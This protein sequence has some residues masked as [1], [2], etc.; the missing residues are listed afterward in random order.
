MTNPSFS[1]FISLFSS[2]PEGLVWNQASGFAPFAKSITTYE[3]IVV[4]GQVLSPFT[5]EKLL[6]DLSA[7]ADILVIKE[8][9]N[10]AKTTLFGI[11]IFI[12]VVDENAL[13]ER[14]QGLSDKYLIDLVYQASRPTMS[15]P[16]LLIMDMDS[17]MI[18]ME[19]IDEIARLANRYDDVASVTAQAMNGKLGFGQS[20]HT[21]VACL[22]GVNLDALEHI[23][24]Q[25]PLMP[26]LL[27]LVT[28]LKKCNWKIAIA[29]GGFTYF[30]DYL[31]DLLGLDF[32]ISNVLEIENN[33]LTGKTLGQVVDA[34]VKAE[35]L[36]RLQ[37]EWNIDKGQVCAIGDGANDLPM[38]ESAS[39]G[40]AFHAKPKVR[41][42]ADYV[43]SYQP[44][45]ALLLLLDR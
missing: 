3:K 42:Q 6:Y 15:E 16:G 14:L 19:C 30:A 45:D 29:S 5:V 37:S 9:T 34:R 1:S 39:L 18:Q 10:N 21:R 43:V 8:N 33:T 7:T 32:S 12:D 2:S 25:L 22:S 36:S 24:A 13:K 41:A 23:K 27:H 4:I 38:L 35:T 20:L 28:E 17:T 26:G 31:K 40:V 44:L 11:D